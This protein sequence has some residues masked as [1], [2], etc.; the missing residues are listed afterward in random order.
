[1]ALLVFT[2][3]H[4]SPDVH[5]EASVIFD[6]KNYMTLQQNLQKL[7]CE[8]FPTKSFNNRVN[9][10][11]SPMWFGNIDKGAGGVDWS[12]VPK[13][14]VREFFKEACSLINDLAEDIYVQRLRTKSSSNVRYSENERYYAIRFLLHRANDRA[15]ALGASVVVFCDE[16]SNRKTGQAISKQIMDYITSGRTS[17]LNPPISRVSL[18][19]NFTSSIESVGVQAADIVAYVYGRYR[20]NVIS[21]KSDYLEIADL[22]RRLAK[23]QHSRVW[24]NR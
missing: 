21:R 22:I 1:M 6:D 5:H 11:A 23:I 12:D 16:D 17:P 24:P 7:A 20:A 8:F 4:K 2:D 15:L 10:H 9:I 3:E 13:E 14:A 19:I 18:P